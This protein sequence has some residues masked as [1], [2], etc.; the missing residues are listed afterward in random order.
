G[1]SEAPT[2]VSRAQSEAL[3]RQ[4]PLAGA[5]VVS[6]PAA[7]STPRGMLAALGLFA[8]AALVLLALQ[9]GAP[10]PWQET[11]PPTAR[12]DAKSSAPVAP[13]GEHERSGEHEP[14]EAPSEART[15]EAPSEVR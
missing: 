2:Q 8:S 13:W 4:A 12:T 9:I 6:P 11:D 15:T 14:K 1:M 7:T 5:T 3:Q 10:K